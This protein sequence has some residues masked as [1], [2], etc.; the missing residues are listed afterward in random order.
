MIMTATQLR[1]DIYKVIDRVVE[2]GVPVEVTRKGGTVRVVPVQKRSKL[3]NL[4]KRNIFLVPPEDLVD[5]GWEDSW[6]PFI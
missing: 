1:K 3:A 6:K 4:K 5:I 2:T